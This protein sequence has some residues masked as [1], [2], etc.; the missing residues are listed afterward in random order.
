MLHAQVDKCPIPLTVVEHNT[1]D[2]KV[3]NV[4][5]IP[6]HDFQFGV[7]LLI[8]EKFDGPLT[9]RWNSEIPEHFSIRSCLL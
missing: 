1:D 4:C 8:D 6:F 3:P 7:G 5:K 9:A 2:Q